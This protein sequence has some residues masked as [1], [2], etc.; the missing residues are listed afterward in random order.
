MNC[1]HEMLSRG[2]SKLKLNNQQS[3][4]SSNTHTKF[5]KESVCDVWDD[6]VVEWSPSN[7]FN[8]FDW[9]SFSL[10]FFC[11]NDIPQSDFVFFAVVLNCL[12]THQ[13]QPKNKKKAK[14]FKSLKL[15][16]CFV[17]QH[18]FIQY[19]SLYIRISRID[20]PHQ[21]NTN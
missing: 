8:E 16:K 13:T 19:S 18:K 3:S 9:Y 15:S 1:K 14:K 21:L 11:Q 20:S 17:P 12:C 7:V 10:C 4:S 2:N 5:R 6:R